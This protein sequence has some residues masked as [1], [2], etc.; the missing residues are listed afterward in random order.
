MAK[1]ETTRRHSTD[2]RSWA[3]AA[4]LALLLAA[5]GQTVQAAPADPLPETIP[6]LPFPD[7][8]DPTLCGIP[9][10][11]DRMGVATGDVDGQVIRPIVYLYDSHLRNAITG[12]IYPGTQVQIKLS[13]SNPELNYYFV[14]SIN[15]EPKQSGWVPAPFVRVES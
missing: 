14:E 5:C 13:Q 11:D 8:P 7:N 9:T 1:L 6:A 3:L 12:Q 4:L 15:V 10:P 2:W